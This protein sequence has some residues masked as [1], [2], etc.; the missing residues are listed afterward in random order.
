MIYSCRVASLK[1]GLGPVPSLFPKMLVDGIVK[2]KYGDTIVLD[3]G[4]P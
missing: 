2:E 1:A 4:K 3:K